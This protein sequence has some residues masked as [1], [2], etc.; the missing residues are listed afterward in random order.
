MENPPASRA[1]GAADVKAGSTAGAARLSFGDAFERRTQGLHFIGQRLGF[2]ARRRRLG[3]KRLQALGQAR[4]AIM[5][6]TACGL[7]LNETI[8]DVCKFAPAAKDRRDLA[9]AEHDQTC[10]H[11]PFKAESEAEQGQRRQT[12]ASRQRGQHARH[13]PVP[14]PHPLSPPGRES[15]DGEST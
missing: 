9:D 2:A 14:L 6:L 11:Q 7:N 1:A 12:G 4:A 10:G 5:F 3:L 15:P 13:K 8:L